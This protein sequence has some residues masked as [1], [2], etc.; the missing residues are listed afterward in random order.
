MVKVK[1]LK[2]I[3]GIPLIY[4]EGQVYF[5]NKTGVITAEK[6][7][8]DKKLLPNIEK[9][10]F[11]TR[12]TL[13]PIITNHAISGIRQGTTYEEFTKVIRDAEMGTNSE[14]MGENYDN[15][16]DNFLVSY[17]KP[18]F[19][20]EEA[21]AKKIDSIVVRVGYLSDTVDNAGEYIK[22]NLKNIIE[23]VMRFLI[24]SKKLTL[25]NIAP[26]S[27]KLKS[28]KDYTKISLLEFTY[29]VYK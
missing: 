27:L 25:H 5:F 3:A 9:T 15:A 11:D 23:R 24:D 29:A 22:N 20:R 6:R 18:L 19:F 26:A 7:E 28:V 16:V 14:K 13:N 12:S 21:N 8:L 10:I 2:Y 1:P 17:E 4:K